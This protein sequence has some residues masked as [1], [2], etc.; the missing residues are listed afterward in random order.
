MACMSNLDKDTISSDETHVHL[1]LW[2]W[3]KSY[4][5]L[6]KDTEKK[7]HK[8]FENDKDEQRQLQDEHQDKTQSLVQPQPFVYPCAEPIPYTVFP[9]NILP[10]AGPAMVLPVL[11]PEAIKSKSI[12]P[13][14]HVM[15]F[16][17]SPGVPIFQRQIPDLTGLKNAQLPLPL[18]QPFMH[19]VPQPL[20]HT[21]MLP[22]EP[23]LSLPQPKALPLSQQVITHPQREMPIQA[24]LFYQEP[25]LDPT[26]G[27][28]P[29]SQQIATVY[30]LQHN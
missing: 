4:R 24:L 5:Y 30:S 2:H 26:Q 13:K 10:L 20:I 28:Y 21:P 17:K 18:L 6:S 12:F 11:K 15:P 27:S 16:L 3:A 22:T 9:Q 1:S 14:R 8:K 23:L 19:Q 29:V 25:L 7:K